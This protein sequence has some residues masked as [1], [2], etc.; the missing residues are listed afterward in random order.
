ME[1][2][3]VEEIRGAEFENARLKNQCISNSEEPVLIF[4]NQE[5]A[6]G[7]EIGQMLEEFPYM[8]QTDLLV[9]CSHAPVTADWYGILMD[10][11]LEVYALVVRRALFA[12]CGSFNFRLADETNREFLCR[13]AEACTPVFLECSDVN[14]NRKLT[15]Q[16]FRTNAYLLTRYLQPLKMKGCMERAL[17]RFMM[18]AESC[19][20]RDVFEQALKEMLAEDQSYYQK[21][22]LATAPFFVIRGNEICYGILQAF[23]DRLTEALKKCGQRVIETKGEDAEQIHVLQKELF[24]GVI[25]FQANILF[26]K[27]FCFV[28]GRRFNFWF[29]HPMFFHELIGQSDAPVIFLCQDKD[30]ADYVNTY[31]S[32]ADG[33][34]FPPGGM[35]AQWSDEEKPYDISF[36]GTYFDERELWNAVMMQEG[37]LGELARACVEI[38]LNHVAMSYNELRVFLAEMY[39]SIF[40]RYPFEVIAGH[41]WKA[42][43]I[44]PYV[45]RRRVVEK[46]L[47]GGYELHVYGESWNDYPVKEGERLVIHEQIKPEEMADKM[48]RSKISLNVMSWHKAGMTERIIEIMMSG[49][50]CLT[51]ETRALREHFSQMEDIVMFRL[52]ELDGLSDLIGRLLSDDKQREAIAKRAY[53]K[54]LARHTWR[55]R[56]MQLVELVGEMEDQD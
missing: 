50:V 42:A 28:R 14:W 9:L 1:R 41:L 29:D 46:I 48:R 7:E 39:P 20:C 27:R 34:W 38:L 53:E 56:A 21:I 17:G 5:V 47:E 3:R 24:R 36:I 19:E 6:A 32:N 18:F 45:C 35:P 25:G 15:S 44:A 40:E 55:A 13:A 31:F 4:V 12:L 26:Q 30:H 2:Y 54:V 10:P 33:I 37:E 16:I 43:R 23:A 8:E 51:D 11:E 52:D 22:Y 49:S